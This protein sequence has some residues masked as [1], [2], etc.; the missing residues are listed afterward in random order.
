MTN[1]V[2]GIGPL[3]RI[4]QDQHPIHHPENPLDLTAE[5]RVARSI[6]DVDLGAVPAHRRVLGQNG[7]APLTLERV[8]VH[9]ALLHLL[10]GP[11]RSRLPEHLVHQG[12]FAVIDMGDDRQVTDQWRIQR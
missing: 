8:G 3:G 12:S 9:H 11:K 4:D 5:V 2:C 10:V 7:D 1:R 6:D